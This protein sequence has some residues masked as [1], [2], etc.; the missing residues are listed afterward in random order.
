[1][2]L[3]L[4]SV[5]AINLLAANFSDPAGRIWEIAQDLDSK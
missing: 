1:M 3:S 4:K 2:T 5:N